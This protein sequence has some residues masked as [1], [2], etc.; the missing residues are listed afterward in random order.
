MRLPQ[1]VLSTYSNLALR[2]PLFCRPILRS[3]LVCLGLRLTARL[4]DY[5]I[6]F[7]VAF[8]TDDWSNV[9]LHFASD[10]G[11][12]V[13]NTYF[14]CSLTGSINI[15]EGFKQSLDGFDRHLKRSLSVVEGPHEHG[16]QV[17]FVWVGRYSALDAPTLELSARQTLCFEHGL[18]VL[19]TDE[20]LPGHGEQ[21]E[22]WIQ[23]YQPHLNP[24][25]E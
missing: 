25:Y 11:Y 15:V 2:A 1:T 22:Q 3:I 10:A 24:S 23:T 8:K 9:V 20:F 12:E 18:I 14:D 5:A 16:E 21:A 6:D 7:E 13:R 4:L 17:S 19:I